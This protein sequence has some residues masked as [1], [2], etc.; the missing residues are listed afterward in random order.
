[1]TSILTDC[2][3]NIVGRVINLI[4]EESRN[5]CCFKCIV[6]D[7]EKEK[8][9][10]EAKWRTISKDIEDAKRRAEDIRDDVIHWEVE[11]KKFIDE[12]TKTKVPCFGGW[13]PNC[14]WRYQRGKELTEM[15]NDVRRLKGTNFHSVGRSPHLPGVETHSSQETEDRGVKLH[16][17]VR[18]VALWIANGDIQSIQLSRKNRK[19]L[20]EKEMKVKYLFCNDL[21]VRDMD[22][23]PRRFDASELEIL[24]IYMEVS[25]YVKVSDAFLEKMTRLRVL[26]LVHNFGSKL[27]LT[28]P[29]SLQSLSNIRSLTLIDWELGDISIFGTLAILEILHLLGCSISE[30]PNEIAK[31]EKLRLLQLDECEIE[32]NNPFEVIERCSQLEELYFSGNEFSVDDTVNE[33]AAIHQN[34]TLPILN[35]YHLEKDDEMDDLI[36]KI[37]CL[38]NIDALVS[39]ATFKALVQGAEILQLSEIVGEWRNLIPEI[40]PMEDNGMNDLI[41]LSLKSCSKVK[42]L[43]NTMHSDCG[44]PNAFSKLVELNLEDMDNLEDLFV[45]PLPLEF[46]KSLERLYF[47]KCEKLQGMFFKWKFNLCNLKIMEVDDCPMLTSLFQ[48][49]TARSLVLLEELTI[50]H[51]KELRNIITGEESKD[52]EEEERIDGNK[53]YDIMFPKLRILQIEDCRRLECIS[54][55][56]TMF[57]KLKILEVKN[58]DRLECIF[59][60]FYL[61]DIPQLETM[62]IIHCGEL[63]YIFGGW[64]QEEEEVIVGSSQERDPSQE[65]YPPTSSSSSSRNGSKAKQPNS[66]NSKIFPWSCCYPKKYGSKLR[67][68][69]S[70]KMPMNSIPGQGFQASNSE[71][72]RT[73]SFFRSLSG[74]SQNLSNIRIMRLWKCSKMA[75]VFTISFT[76]IMLLEKLRVDECHELK[77]IITYIR[78]DEDRKNCSSIFPKLKEISIQNCN[79]FKYLIGPNRHEECNLELHIDLPALEQLMLRF[80]PNMINICPK[81]YF[82]TWPTLKKFKSTECPQS[83]DS[84]LVVSLYSRQFINTNKDTRE[85]EKHFLTLESVCIRDSEVKSMFHV[86]ELQ[87]GFEI[88][89]RPL[90]MALKYLELDN[91]PQLTCICVASKNSLTFQHLQT[92]LIVG[93]AKLEL[94]FP[95]SVLRCLPELKRLEIIECKELKQIIEE[96]AEN[97]KVSPQPCFPKLAAF[98]VRQCHKLKCFIATNDLPNLQYL[99][100]N[101]ASELEELFGFE[102]RQGDDEIRRVEVKLP[103]LKIVIFMDLQSLCLGAET[104]Q[105]TRYRVV[106]NCPKLSMTSTTSLE[107]LRDEYFHGDLRG[108]IDPKIHD[109]SWIDLTKMLNKGTTDYLLEPEIQRGS[110]SKLPS[111]QTNEELKEEFVEKVASSEI[112]AVSPT[113]SKSEGLDRPS[114]SPLDV[115]PY[116]THSQELANGQS[117]GES[118]LMNHQKSLRET[119]SNIEISQGVDEKETIIGKDRASVKPTITIPLPLHSIE[120]AVKECF[121]EGSNLTHK[122]G[123]IGAISVDNIIV[124]QRN[125]EP[126]K[127]FIG[128][129]SIS[130]MLVIAASP[131]DSDMIKGSSPSLSN[132]PL[133]NIHSNCTKRGVEE[134]ATSENAKVET[135]SIHLKLASSQPSPSVNPQS[136][137]YPDNEISLSQIEAY[138]N[139]E[140]E[141]HPTNIEDLRDDDLISLFQ[142][143][144]EDSDS[145]IGTTSISVVSADHPVS[146]DNLVVNVLADMEESL[147][148][149]L[150]DIASSEANSLRLLTAL[151]FLSRLSSKHVTLS[152]GLKAII[153]SL[154]KE[155]P[156]ILCSFKQAFATTNKFAVLEEK[157]KSIKEELAHRKEVA[158]ALVSKISKAKYFMDEAQQKEATLKEQMNRLEKEMKDCEADLSSLQEEKTK[159]VAETMGYKKEFETVRNDRSQMM[160]D[161]RNA[162]QKL[163]E[164]DYKWSVLCSQFENNRIT[165]SNPS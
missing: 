118:S 143:E 138:I 130:E 33:V 55:I 79:Q 45:G 9:E 158:T 14:I 11:A 57:P 128:R 139:K 1:M 89:K 5:V 4:V 32:R 30:L 76:S 152:K 93:C 73:V 114:P 47:K 7:F 27:S 37:I 100:I 156:S 111:S 74:H 23:F 141:G 162:W 12:D 137:S 145:Q 70:I 25:G 144:E 65:S 75:S 112:P 155:F 36:S 34:T 44:V 48:P 150:K 56:H 133:P 49:S 83:S 15:T 102:Q 157:E 19:A 39:E 78:D 140:T 134:G 95:I 29:V 135:L 64:E 58:C 161:Q 151:N 106:Y 59:P 16:D 107:E 53:G 147:K 109:L 60:I 20:G 67:S 50:R 113:D 69:T 63:K 132:I 110:G 119:E 68:G 84:N 136:E 148:M 51:C 165:A 42:C 22:V 122:E 62:D 120:A 159:F 91:L 160:E 97:Q 80:L 2:A 17:L 38:P 18:E 40:V 81:N 43:M 71:C 96:D 77:Q 117:M 35:R 41:E 108:V 31:L 88:I 104:L 21:E 149:P 101:G 54:P 124:N 116:K 24:L 164:I 86:D 154:H 99:I 105:T 142:L 123:E 26:F 6:D 131:T 98:T 10:L 66:P 146:K 52:E 129:A 87:D 13:C 163:S 121:Q 127:E 72:N 82:I 94:L 28:L 46:L 103:K 92:L 115:T 153:D 61:R 3:N 126:K 125:E 90:S 85:I 8:P